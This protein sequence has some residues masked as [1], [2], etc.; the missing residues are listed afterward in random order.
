MKWYDKTSKIRF[1]LP[2]DE[3]CFY[4]ER[5]NTEVKQISDNGLVENT[6]PLGSMHK[7][8]IANKVMPVIQ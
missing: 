2:T 8:I 3:I 6:F 7:F 1:S 4:M 5:Y